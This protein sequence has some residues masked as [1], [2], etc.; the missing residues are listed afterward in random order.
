MYF[1][2]YRMY[3]QTIKCLLTAAD[4]FV[5]VMRQGMCTEWVSEFVYFELLTSLF[6][7]IDK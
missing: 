4:I 6:I 2:S 3:F 5:L 7:G 1:V